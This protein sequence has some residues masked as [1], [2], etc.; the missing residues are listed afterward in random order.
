MNVIPQSRIDAYLYPVTK[1]EMRL[2]REVG[3]V[4]TAVCVEA[5]DVKTVRTSDGVCALEP[6][7]LCGSCGI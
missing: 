5:D 6:A 2:E 1:S 7:C 3:M 4:L